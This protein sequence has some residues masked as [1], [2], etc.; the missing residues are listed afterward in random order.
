MNRSEVILAI[1]DLLPSIAKSGDASAELTKHATD[2]HLAP[3][4]LRMM[5]HVYNNLLALTHLSRAEDRA[6]EHPILDVGTMV[7]KY[8]SFCP[9]QKQEA[10]PIPSS[11]SFKLVIK[12]AS[13]EEAWGIKKEAS[14]EQEVVRWDGRRSEEQIQREAL[15][16]SAFLAER[17]IEQSLEKLAA[18]LTAD[19]CRIVLEDLH[20]HDEA[21]KTEFAELLKRA[22]SHHWMDQYPKEASAGPRRLDTDRTGYI[23]A[24][25]GAAEL[26]KLAR[27]EEALAKELDTEGPVDL[28][29]PPDKRKG[30]GSGG[31]GGQGSGNQPAG[32][33]GS[34]NSSGGGQGS[35][36]QPA[37]RKGSGS[38]KP[39]AGSAGNL[40]GL[41]LP[42]VGAD[43]APDKEEKPR[44]T[45]ATA[46]LNELAND[47]NLVPFFTDRAKA[48]IPKTNEPQ[49]RMDQAISAE[50]TKINLTRLIITDPVIS[51]RNP[52]EV[53]SYAETLIG[54]D[55]SLGSDYNRLRWALREALE[56]QG[57]PEDKV[58]MLIETGKNRTDSALKGRELGKET[59]GLTP[60][61]E[62]KKP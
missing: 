41:I 37:G 30:S 38:G 29:A 8:A 22:A 19:R 62:S 57:V 46:T 20:H 7:D 2:N 16:E 47:L 45:S 53:A 13:L 6:S 35:G 31:G 42:I 5:G 56:Y 10:E 3:E 54:Q 11:D 26:R 58:K 21:L 23:A 34:G 25:A 49:R 48:L 9:E 43:R 50:R 36:N 14:S 44:Q 18:D 17:L 60:M 24:L 59:Y 28:N 55:P 39:T 52:S 61:F 15:A 12:R 32:R 1:H 4:Q 51:T 40:S 33:K 27:D